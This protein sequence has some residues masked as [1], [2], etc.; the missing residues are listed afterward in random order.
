MGEL[1]FLTPVVQDLLEDLP[2]SPSA[3]IITLPHAAEG[4][5]PLRHRL[6]P[7]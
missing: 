5:T 1:G 7:L 2:S 3:A 4:I 6:L